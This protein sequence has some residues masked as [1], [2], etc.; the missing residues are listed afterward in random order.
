MMMTQSKDQHPYAKFI[1]LNI[2][3]GPL[4]IAMVTA[5]IFAAIPLLVVW[6]IKLQLFISPIFWIA[7]KVIYTTA[8]AIF[9]GYLGC[10]WALYRYVADGKIS[11][12]A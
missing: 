7:F 12:N 8:V 2:I 11:I 3:L 5:F 1:P 9:A 4:M 6:L 10:I